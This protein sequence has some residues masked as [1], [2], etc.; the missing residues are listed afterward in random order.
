MGTLLSC[1]PTAAGMALVIMDSGFLSLL[2]LHG[3]L[4]TSFRGDLILSA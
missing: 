1:L 4:E 3:C 2:L